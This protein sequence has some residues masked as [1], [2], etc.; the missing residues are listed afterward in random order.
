MLNQKDLAIVR[1]ALMFLDEEF[2]PEQ[3]ELF[4]HYLDDE[5]ILAKAS[6]HDIKSTRAKF[7]K[8][9]LF[10]ATKWLHRNELVST[11]LTAFPAYDEL[12]YQADREQLVSVLVTAD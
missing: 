3:E 10:S 12:V 9:K 6:V 11:T 2:F 5:R 8:T 1:A 4:Q 7:N